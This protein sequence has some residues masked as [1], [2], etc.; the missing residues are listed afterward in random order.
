MV[1]GLFLPSKKTFGR[2][3]KKKKEGNSRTFS[4]PVISTRA[5]VG[6]KDLSVRRDSPRGS[7]DGRSATCGEFLMKN[8]C[9]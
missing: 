7:Q 9:G 6:D 8:P 3:E 2:T 1:L 5:S 4:F